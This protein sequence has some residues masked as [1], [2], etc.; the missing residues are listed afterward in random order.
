MREVRLTATP[1]LATDLLGR[2]GNRTLAVTFD[3][4]F[5][6]VFEHALPVL[7]KH[8][9]PATCFVPSGYI[10]REAGWMAKSTGAPYKLEQLASAE[11]LAA[12]DCRLITIGSHSVS[13]HPL[14]TLPETSLNRE[15][16]DSKE[17]L[18]RIT[19]RR[20]SIL[21]F[22]YGSFS[23]KVLEAAGA[24]GYTQVFA[25][26][27]MRPTVG[28]IPVLIGRITVSPHD[29]PLE[30]KLK[31]RGA[32]DWLVLGIPA[33]RALKRWVTWHRRR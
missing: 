1:V 11:V 2:Q 6:N 19:S 15:L 26:V 29:W 3:D 24:A 12:A 14:A 20:V 31:V 33:K 10:G 13:H 18:E 17:T 21:S 8:R 4:G 23:T 9:I 27:P 5:Q 28:S 25:N 7:A 30:F 16:V 22:P 32:Y